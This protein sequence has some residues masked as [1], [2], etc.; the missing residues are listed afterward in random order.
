MV[1]TRGFTMIELM[2]VVLIIGLIAAIVLVNINDSRKKGRDARR[3]SDLQTTQAAVEQYANENRKYP[4]PSIGGNCYD[5]NISLD[6]T[7]C[8]SGP[9]AMAP[10][11]TYRYDWIPD[12]VGTAGAPAYLST[13]PK[14]PGT[15]SN[16]FVYIYR[17]AD[18]GTIYK[19]CATLEV[20]TDSMKNDG[21]TWASEDGP[22]SW[23]ELFTPGQGTVMTTPIGG[24]DIMCR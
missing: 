19:L 1:K 17:V 24:S 20:D 3:K 13:V 6:A 16:P 12:L 8:A 2:V 4:V 21:G 22:D 5:T 23:Y 9:T 11:L 18:D 10:D 14:D 7:S 15:N